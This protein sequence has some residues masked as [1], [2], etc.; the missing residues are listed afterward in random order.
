MSRQQHRFHGDPERFDVVAE[1]INGKY[2][3]SIR[4]I[5]D[6]AGG[7]GMLSRILRKRYNYE[8]EVVDPR[9]WKPRGGGG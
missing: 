5:A 7:R 4:Y 3:K 6:V 1:F 8:S 2:G 9:G